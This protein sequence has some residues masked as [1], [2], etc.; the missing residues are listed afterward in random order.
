MTLTSH[1]LYDIIVRILQTRLL[2]ASA[3]K[4]HKLILECFHPSAK[5][6]TPYLFVDNLRTDSCDKIES[7]P[8]ML[9]SGEDTDRLGK[10]RGLYSHFRPLLPDEAHRAPGH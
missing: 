3:L 7:E 4:R 6:F 10:L 5:V 2:N 8:Q 1:R 9:V